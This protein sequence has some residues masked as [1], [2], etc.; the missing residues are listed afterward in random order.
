M[1]AELVEAT[2]RAIDEHGPDL[3]I[4]D[5]VKTAEV[6]RPKLYR[7]FDDKDALFDAVGDRVQEMIIERVVPHFDLTD[8]ALG[9]VRSTLT[10]YVGLVAERPN[11]FRFLVGSHFSDGGRSTMDLVDGG[12]PLSDATAAV[13]AAVVTGRGGDGE[14]LEYFVDAVLGA[15]ALGVL[16]WLNTPAISEIALVEELTTFVWGAMSA[17]AAA[18]GVVLDPDERLALP[19]S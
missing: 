5:V 10:A 6:P 11:V 15:V 13:V 18:R 12:R 1:R 17:T 9:L 4:D 2:L 14:N 16:R 3:S 19:E 8:T 7:F